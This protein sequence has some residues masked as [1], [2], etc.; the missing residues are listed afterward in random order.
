[1]TDDTQRE[2]FERWFAKEFPNTNYLADRRDLECANI[3]S[4]ARRSWQAAIRH[5]REQEDKA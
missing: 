3:R 4:A 2:A 1:M 5:M